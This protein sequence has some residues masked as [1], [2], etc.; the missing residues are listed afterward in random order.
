MLRAARRGIY[1]SGPHFDDAAVA[2][3]QGLMFF[4]D[5]WIGL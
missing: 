4:W 1:I 3:Q 2:R 5:D